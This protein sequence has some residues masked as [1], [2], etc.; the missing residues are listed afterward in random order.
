MNT[1]VEFGLRQKPMPLVAVARHWFRVRLEFQGVQYWLGSGRLSLGI[2]D[3]KAGF[4]GLAEEES[5]H[6]II[7][8]ICLSGLKAWLNH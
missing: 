8:R 4:V 5:Q 3:R 2:Y 1:L 6:F 7:N